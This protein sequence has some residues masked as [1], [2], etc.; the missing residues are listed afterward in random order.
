M[1]LNTSLAL[2]VSA[3][4]VSLVNGGALLDAVLRPRAVDEMWG[5]VNI[6]AS[7]LEVYNAISH[8]T[9]SATD[10]C[11]QL[12]TNVYCAICMSNPT[13][14]TTTPDQTQAA[15]E[16]H[17]NYHKGCAIWQT[18]RN[19]FAARSLSTSQPPTTSAPLPTATQDQSNPGSSKSSVSTGAIVGI[20]IG[21][22]CFLAV[23]AAATGFILNTI[24]SL[25]MVTSAQY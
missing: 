5:N 19:A 25:S 1:K 17:A 10:Y 16:G 21:G 7:V 15:T 6:T 3:V 20:V 9:C 14:N 2:V 18:Y 24:K 12:A 11:V 22:V 8:P 13:D 23:V 4:A